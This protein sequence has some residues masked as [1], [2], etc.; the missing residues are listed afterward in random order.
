MKKTSHPWDALGESSQKILEVTIAASRAMNSNQPKFGSFCW[1]L[2]KLSEGNMPSRILRRNPSKSLCKSRGNSNR[3]CHFR[4][5]DTIDLLHVGTTA[6]RELAM[7][8]GDTS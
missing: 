3:N 2:L 4:L 7:K 6:V 8:P 1:V 5:E